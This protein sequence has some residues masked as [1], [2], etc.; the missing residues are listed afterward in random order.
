M[1]AKAIIPMAGPLHRDLP[2][3]HVTTGNGQTQQIV[4]LQ[5]QEILDAGIREVALVT[6]PGTRIFFAE[7]EKRFGSRVV[8]VEQA[9]PRGFG[10]ALQ[11]AEAWVGAE[12]FL[13]QVC[14]HVFVTHAESSCTAQVLEVFARE[15]AAVSAVQV[16]AESELPYFGV[17]GG[18]RVHGSKSLYAIQ[19]VLEKPTPTVAEETCMIPGIRQG[20]YLALFG[21]HALT[22]AVFGLLRAREKT[23]A[24]GEKLGLTEALAALCARERYLAVELEGHRVDIEG[25]FGLLRAQLAFALHG[26]RREEAMRLL[27]EEVA[28]AER[29]RSSAR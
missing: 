5:I 4:A 14:D 26:P 23:L 20:N 3:Q 11:C 18:E 2:F 19:T 25:P 17:I 7:L 10:H 27:L 13:V 22:P 12:P 15:N 1:L 28:H 16:T 24:E 9:E 8:L 6:A 21:T 29:T